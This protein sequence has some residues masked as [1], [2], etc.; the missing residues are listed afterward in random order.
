[1]NAA[2]GSLY[3]SDRPSFRRTTVVHQDV[4]FARESAQPGDK[5]VHGSELLICSL[6]E[7]GVSI[8]LFIIQEFV[9]ESTME[10]TQDLQAK[11]LSM[12]NWRT[13]DEDEIAKRRYRAQTEP[14]RQKRDES[15]PG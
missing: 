11:L 13:T 2:R 1:M 7:V 9:K 12:H 6:S 4:F 3:R 8:A 10:T 5:C 15:L 14:L